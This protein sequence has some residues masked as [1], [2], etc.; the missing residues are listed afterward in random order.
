MTI[1]QDTRKRGLYLRRI[2]QGHLIPGK[3]RRFKELHGDW[4]F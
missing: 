4:P 3:L 1:L 2:F